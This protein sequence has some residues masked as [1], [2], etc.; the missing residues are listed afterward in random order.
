MLE[1]NIEIIKSMIE[2]YQECS[3]EG[4]DMQVDVTFRERQ[5]NALNNILAEREQDKREIKKLKKECSNLKVEMLKNYIPKSKVISDIQVL[6]NMLSD[7]YTKGILYNTTPR[8]INIQ[9]DT[10]ECLL[11]E[12]EVE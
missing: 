7:S 3:I 9:I 2:E 4:E 5:A 11:K 6:K 1:K 12:C 8:N 10:L